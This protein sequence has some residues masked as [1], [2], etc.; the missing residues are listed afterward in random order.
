MLNLKR[1]LPPLEPLIAFEA[2]CRHMSFTKAAAELSLSQAAVSQQIRNLE[3][4]LDVD[5]FI[6]SHRTISLSAK[7]RELQH[8]VS[9]ALHQLATAADELKITGQQ[10]RLTVAADQSIA[11]MWLMPHLTQFQSSHPDVSVRVIASDI[12]EDC[13]GD[14]IHLSFLLGDGNWQGYNSE[15]LFEEEIFPVCSPNY[16][17]PKNLPLDSQNLVNQTLLD[18]DDNHWNWMNWRTWLSKNQIHLAATQRRFQ[19]NSYPLLI[20]AAKNSQG[21]ALGWKHLVD[22]DLTSGDLVRVTK[23]SIKTEFGYYLIW[24][25]SSTLGPTTDDFKI[26]CTNQVK[27]NPD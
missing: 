14:D 8:S 1:R 3:K 6:R 24:D 10:K 5:L 23:E 11:S 19:I 17:S 25:E 2:A 22:K 26:W 21:I 13:F 20:E 12:E 15:L 18:L 7:G 27:S 9:S 4:S 16:L